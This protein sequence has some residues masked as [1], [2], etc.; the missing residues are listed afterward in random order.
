MAGLAAGLGLVTY[1]V[2]TDG[3]FALTQ[4]TDET[5]KTLERNR[6]ILG[7]VLTV[8]GLALAAFASPVLGAGVAAGGLAALAGTQASLAL[9]HVLDKTNADGSLQTAKLSGVFAGGRQRLGAVF[10]D[11]GRQQ[12][13]AVFD[14]GAQV[15]T[16]MGNFYDESFPG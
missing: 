10:N 4:R 3:A 13:G 8:G 16:G 11:R 6:M 12:L 14:G 15:M 5:L 9:G 2:G 1:A 7:G